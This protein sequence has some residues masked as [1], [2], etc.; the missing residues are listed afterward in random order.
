M[1]LLLLCAFMFWGMHV[2]LSI[3]LV[4]W[5]FQQSGVILDFLKTMEV[6]PDSYNI[7]KLETI[8]VSYNISK[9]SNDSILSLQF[10]VLQGTVSI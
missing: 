8:I 9:C 7:L 6:A 10:Q 3:N 2:I 4:G 1:N 5:N